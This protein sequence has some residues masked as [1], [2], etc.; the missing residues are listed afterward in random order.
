MLTPPDWIGIRACIRRGLSPANTIRPHSSALVCGA[1]GMARS[2]IYS[3]ISLGVRNIFV[4]NRNLANAVALIEYYRDLVDEG[5]LSELT[6]GTASQIQFQVLENFTSAWP[7]NA[8][9][10]TIIVNCIPRLDSDDTAIL[11]SLPESWL[12]SL[13]GGVIVEVILLSRNRYSG[14]G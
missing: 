6:S 2:A 4:C 1:G 8:R 12:K 9:Q 7:S 13:T 5:G 3:L 14:R 10:P 11:V